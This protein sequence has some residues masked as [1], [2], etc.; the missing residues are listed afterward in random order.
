MSRTFYH[1]VCIATYVVFVSIMKDPRRRTDLTCL[2]IAA[3]F[4]ARLS[5]IANAPFEEVT[6]LTRMASEAMKTLSQQELRT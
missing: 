5:L 1:L 3:G 2:G 4:F 6:E